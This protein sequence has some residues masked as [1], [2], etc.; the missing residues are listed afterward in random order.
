MFI[1]RKRCGTVKG[2]G[3]ADGRKQ[4]A[5]T[6]KE[7]ATSPTIATEAVFLTAVIAALE[8]RDV[9]VVDVPGAFMQ[10]D[11]DELVHVRFTGTM[12]DML[13]EI[14]YE[15]YSPFITYEGKNKVLYVELLGS[16]WDIARLPI[17]LGEAL[18]QITG[19]GVYLK[20]I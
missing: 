17:V 1:K 3:C 10:T 6:D 9:A 14:D 16:L 2:R 18:R 12:V 13:L 8:G 7:E 5:Y 4:R 19:V 15:M 20:P 11:L